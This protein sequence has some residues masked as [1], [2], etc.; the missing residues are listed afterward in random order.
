MTTENLIP[1][2]SYWQDNGHLKVNDK[3]ISQYISLVYL[4]NYNKMKSVDEA[5]CFLIR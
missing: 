4:V 5:F 2:G 3:A 1:T